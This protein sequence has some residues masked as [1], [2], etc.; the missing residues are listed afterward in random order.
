MSNTPFS[1]AWLGSSFSMERESVMI[2]KRPTKALF[3]S[4]VRPDLADNP[5]SS[6]LIRTLPSPLFGILSI[7]VTG[8]MKW[9]HDRTPLR[10]SVLGHYSQLREGQP[11]LLRSR[12]ATLQGHRC[13]RALGPVLI[14]RDDQ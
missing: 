5:M 4:Y 9:T 14:R 12:L 13:P 10:C 3:V 1:P 2:S 6:T 11:L 7:I 8:M